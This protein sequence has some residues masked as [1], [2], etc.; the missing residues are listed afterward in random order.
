MCVCAMQAV[1]VAKE[2]AEREQEKESHPNFEGLKIG[3]CT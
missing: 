3:L 2:K 1:H